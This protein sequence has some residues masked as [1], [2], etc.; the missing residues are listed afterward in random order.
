MVDTV[1]HMHCYVCRNQLIPPTPTSHAQ[2]AHTEEYSCFNQELQRVALSGIVLVT[3]R[4][5]R[6]LSVA[7]LKNEIFQFSYHVFN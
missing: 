1:N 2:N 7:I 6:Q 5:N 3:E 4:S